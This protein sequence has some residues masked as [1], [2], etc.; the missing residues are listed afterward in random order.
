MPTLHVGKLYQVAFRRDWSTGIQTYSKSHAKRFVLDSN[1][2]AGQIG[3]HLH[4][5]TLIAE[6]FQPH[7]ALPPVWKVPPTL[8]NGRLVACTLEL[9]EQASNGMML[10]RIEIRDSIKGL[11]AKGI[12]GPTARRIYGILEGTFDFNFQPWPD[13]FNVIPNSSWRFY[14]R[15]WNGTP[16]LV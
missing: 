12:G 6:E 9:T 15:R 4:D 8:L 5:L 2:T 3:G 7:T 1:T 14:A 16:L 10:N 11:V 13:L